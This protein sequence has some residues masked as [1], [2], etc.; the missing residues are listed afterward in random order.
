M[1]FSRITA[2]LMFAATL[3]GTVPAQAGIFE[4]I[5]GLFADEKQ[6]VKPNT[7]VAPA[8]PAQPAPARQRPVDAPRGGRGNRGKHRHHRQ[9]VRPVPVRPVPATQ[10]GAPW[11][12]PH[13]R[14]AQVPAQS[15]TKATKI[16]R[17]LARS[18]GI[19]GVAAVVAFVG[20]LVLNTEFYDKITGLITFA[21]DGVEG[22]K[23]VTKTKN[24]ING[25]RDDLK[26]L[27]DELVDETPA[28]Q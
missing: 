23:T 8:Q 3:T 18:A 20:G 25:L 21:K 7:P 9:P 11:V 14:P 5:E 16:K 26:G 2:I 24:D 4:W 28:A 13:V 22:L 10:P 17:M 6:E 12:N 27:V 15:V 1:K 19:I